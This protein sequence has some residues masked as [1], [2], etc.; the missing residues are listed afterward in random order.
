MFLGIKYLDWNMAIS[1]I[2]ELLFL[3]VDEYEVFQG[4]H[5][6]RSAC[7]LFD[8][9]VTL[10]IFNHRILHSFSKSHRMTTF[11]IMGQCCFI[12]T[13]CIFDDEAHFDALIPLKAAR[14]WK[15]SPVTP[16]SIPTFFK[17]FEKRRK[18][19]RKIFG[20]G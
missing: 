14:T 20:K 12:R 6:I 13:L 18:K 8:F 2:Y 9:P 3:F 7:I 11:R 15:E 4:R 5:F 1:F 19:R 16:N 17:N 10:Y